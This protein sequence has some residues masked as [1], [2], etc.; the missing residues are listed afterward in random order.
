ME[1]MIITNNKMIQKEM[2]PE[3][4]HNYLNKAQ[5]IKI[6]ITYNLTVFPLTKIIFIKRKSV[7]IN[8]KDRDR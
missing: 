2:F 7:K 5:S 1:L 4:I 3:E 8:S 6:F